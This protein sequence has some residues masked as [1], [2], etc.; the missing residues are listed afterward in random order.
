MTYLGVSSLCANLVNV[1][2]YSVHLSRVMRK[3]VFGVSDQALQKITEDSL[4]L[5]I[6]KYE[7]EEL[8]HLCFRVCKT[9]V[10]E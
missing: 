5:K 7:E 8:Y 9:Q 2:L 4:R 6:R 3:P 10:F 1:K